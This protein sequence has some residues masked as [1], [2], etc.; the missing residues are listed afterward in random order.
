MY[1]AAV[2]PSTLS[3]ANCVLELG[4]QGGTEVVA[5]CSVGVWNKFILINANFS[6]PSGDGRTCPG[7]AGKKLNSN[8]WVGG[9]EGSL[10]V[11]IKKTFF[12]AAKR[13]KSERAVPIAESGQH[14]ESGSFWGLLCV[15]VCVCVLATYGSDR[16]ECR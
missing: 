1:R 15:C 11:L 2:W 4:G 3:R 13:P 7:T 14:A 16:V 5:V 9:G 8:C 12:G 6:R 10:H